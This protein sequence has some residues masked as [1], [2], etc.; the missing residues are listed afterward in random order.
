MPPCHPDRD[1]IDGSYL[2]VTP[3]YVVDDEVDLGSYLEMTAD[4]A[5][6]DT[7]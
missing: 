2:A 1:D 4:E 7:G 5:A 3:D 6:A